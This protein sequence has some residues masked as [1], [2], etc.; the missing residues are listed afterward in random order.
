V[1]VSVSVCVCV[2]LL[3]GTVSVWMSVWITVRRGPERSCCHDCACTHTDSPSCVGA[4]ARSRVWPS[5]STHSRSVCA[6]TR[7]AAQSS[8]VAAMGPPSVRVVCSARC[9]VC[10]WVCGSVWVSVCVCL[11][12]V[13]LACVQTDAA[14]YATAAQTAM[15]TYAHVCVGLPDVCADTGSSSANSAAANAGSGILEGLDRCVCA[16]GGVGVGVGVGVSASV[17]VCVCAGCMCVCVC[18]VGRKINFCGDGDDTLPVEDGGESVCS[19]NSSCSSSSSPF[20]PRCVFAVVVG[21]VVGGAGWGR[22]CW[23]SLSVCVNACR[24]SCLSLCVPLPLPRSVCAWSLCPS[25]LR[26]GECVLV[27]TEDNTSIMSE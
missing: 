19:Y 3:V 14:E 13:W 24:L 7:C 22:S 17:G 2:C 15:S 1:S 21:F 5:R 11:L 25:C 10:L 9:C 18:C 12:L 4:S 20:L 16:R 23:I 8:R 6:H 27:S 26:C